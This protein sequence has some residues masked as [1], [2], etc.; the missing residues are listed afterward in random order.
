MPLVSIIAELRKAQAGRY[1][2]PCFDTFEMMGTEGMFMA[3]E[4]KRSP[5]MVALYAG[6]VDQPHAAAFTAF[7]RALA[8]DSTVPVS[9]FLDHGAS[10]E[11]C[12]KA[13]RLGFS[14]VMYDGSKLPLEENIATTRLVARAAHAVGAC[15]EAELGHV[16]VGSEYGTFGGLRKGFTDP[17]IVERFVAETGVDFLAVAIGTAHGVY[18]GEPH[19]DLELLAEIRQRIGIPLVMHGGSGLSV[20]QFQAAIAAGISKVNIFTDLGLAAREQMIQS[21][22]AENASYFS[23]ASAARQAFRDRCGFYMDI[24]GS[25]GRA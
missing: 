22:R 23:I 1:A 16:G 9:L 13:L 12:I 10:Y 4:E 15:A 18:A 11:Q 5:T 8:Q 20:A 3:I 24:F 19:I 7:V 2:L 6:S 14:D 17:A 21:A 25:T